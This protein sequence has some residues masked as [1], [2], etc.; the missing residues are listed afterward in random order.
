V[1]RQRLVN[2]I[3]DDLPETV[4]ESAAIR[5]ADVHSRTL[6]NGL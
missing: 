2:R 5:A 1:T 3:V 4:H 6:T